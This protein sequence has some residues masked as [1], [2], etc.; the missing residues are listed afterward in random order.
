MPTPADTII[1]VLLV[2][3]PILYVYRDSLPLIGKSALNKASSSTTSNGVVGAA[4]KKKREEQGD[5]RDWLEQMKK[6]VSGPSSLSFL[7]LW[8]IAT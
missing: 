4:G 1:V 7:F 8:F 5:P 6:A 2:L 3:L